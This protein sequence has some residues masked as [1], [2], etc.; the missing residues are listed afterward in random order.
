M[1]KH[2]GKHKL[3]AE[4]Y[5]YNGQPVIMSEYGGIDFQILKKD[6]DTESKQLM[7]MNLYKGLNY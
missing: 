7:K 1:E 5:R 3:F 6:G 4:G 2:N